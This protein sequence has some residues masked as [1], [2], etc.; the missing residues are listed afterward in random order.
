MVSLSKSMDSTTKSGR[1][2]TSRS[3]SRSV[4][5][6]WSHSETRMDWNP[7]VGGL[8][9]NAL[10]RRSTVA[11]ERLVEAVTCS[12]ESTSLQVMLITVS[13]SRSTGMRDWNSATTGGSSTGSTVNWKECSQVFPAGSMTVTPITDCPLASGNKRRRTSP[14]VRSTATTSSLVF[15]N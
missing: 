2:M 14:S 13:T 6:V 4:Q 9:V 7:A 3:T 1:A 11:Q 5:L 8:M 10:L 12:G 15:V